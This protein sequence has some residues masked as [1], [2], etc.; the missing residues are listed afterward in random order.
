[1]E[2]VLALVTGLLVGAAAAALFLRSRLARAHA[3][4]A[5]LG[6]DL[7][8]A[9]RRFDELTQRTDQ[10]SRL[11][12]EL[13]ERVTDLTGR[14][15]AAEAQAERVPRL[16]DEIRS[17][18]A[19]LRARAERLAAL[20]TALDD[21]R[22][23]AQ[24]K[25]ALLDEARARLTDSFRSLASEALSKNNEAF[26]QLATQNLRQ[27]Q[28]AARGDLERRQQ[29]IGELVAPLR[30]QLSRYEKQIQEMETLR[31]K[32]HGE[33]LAQVAH[34]GQTQR[35]LEQE[36]GKL[37]QALRAP[38]VR[39][40]WGEITLRRVVELA[41]MVDRCDFREQVAIDAADGR[42]RPDMIVNLPGGRCIVIDAKTP[43]MAYL[44]ALEA[45]DPDQ[46]RAALQRHAS[47]LHEHMERLAQK[48]YQAQ[49]R[50]A[51]D[52]VV[53]FIPGE[54]FLAAAVDQR[55]DLIERGFERNVILA[56]PSTLISLLKTIAQ[57][58]R[59]EQLAENAQ[60]ISDLGRELYER[61]CTLGDHLGK[62][63]SSL[64]Q[65][66]RHYNRA[67][68]SMESRVLVQARRFNELGVHSSKQLK[69]LQPLDVTPVAPAAE[70]FLP[71]P[72]PSLPD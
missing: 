46:R 6:R 21:E 66:V 31:A 37:V 4:A 30:E 52:F 40:R 41:G 45:A 59:E 61:L 27:H 64:E 12:A 15:H 34:L 39:G 8:E 69:Q 13:R 53:L 38:Q 67:V 18:G 42:L 33:L 48:A 43:L 63:G 16:E 1:M 10:E 35:Q 9:R 50:P 54:S 11:A 68:G 28:E 26:L 70:D 23:A 47:Q 32:A 36:T 20:Q 19:E 58:W 56:T 65:T 72:T 62:V 25:Q 5:L 2:I 29:A 57:G 55:P 24:E 44:E 49:L 51:P 14:L 71:A 7:D 17:L 22:K 3:T 60:R